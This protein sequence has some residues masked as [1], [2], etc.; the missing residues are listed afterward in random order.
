VVGFFAKGPF[1]EARSCLACGDE[2]TGKFDKVGGDLDGRDGG[3]EDRRLAE[4]DL[5]VESL[6]FGFV[7]RI[8]GGSGVRD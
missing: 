7:E 4:G 5:F 6:A 2:L 8:M 3:L 1:G